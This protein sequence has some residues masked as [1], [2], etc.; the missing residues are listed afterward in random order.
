MKLN[1]GDA[2]AIVGASDILDISQ[3]D[4]IDNLVKKLKSFGLKVYVSDLLFEKS[5]NIIELAKNKAKVLNDFYLDKRVKAIFDVSGGNLA[6][7]ILDYIDYETIKANPKPFFGYSDVSVV[8]N[9]LY[10][11]TKNEVYLY[12]IK[13]IVLECEKIQSKEFEDFIFG[14][15]DNLLKF[16]Y[17]WIQGSTMNGEVLG[18]NIRCLLKL[19]G[20]KYMPS[21]KGKILLLESLSGGVNMMITLLTQFKQQGILKDIKG[22]ILGNFTEMQKNN[23]SPNISEV[24]KDIVNNKEIPIVKTNMIGHNKDSKCVR[25]GGIV[26][27]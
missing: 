12:Q 14:V 24:V 3:K 1:K 11:Q 15:N 6:N 20:T 9:S 7:T 10:S 23:L 8:L 18:G 5:L 13:N 16:D 17:E 22:I 27:L 25:I 26:K 21:F 19:S 4:I 2:I